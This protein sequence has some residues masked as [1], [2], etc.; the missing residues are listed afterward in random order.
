AGTVTYG[1]DE[2]GQLTLVTL[3]DG[4]TIEYRYDEAGNRISTTQDGQTTPY[5]VDV[6][7]RVTAAG[8]TTYRYDADGNLIS[9]TENG[10]TTTYTWDDLNRLT[11][12]SSPGDSFVYAYDPFGN[13]ISA[14]HNGQISRYVIDPISGGNRIADYGTGDT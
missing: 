6:M 7:N 5:T 12:V 11:G 9:R 10:I 8:N 14:T 3:P 1:S 13:R 2:A 4:K